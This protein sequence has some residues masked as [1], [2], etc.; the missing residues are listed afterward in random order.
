MNEQMKECIKKWTCRQTNEW[1]NEHAS[2][3]NEW[4]NAVMNEQAIEIGN[5][6][7]NT[8]LRN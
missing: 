8:D 2:K 4:K 5:E 3:R 6:L 1:T 7:Q